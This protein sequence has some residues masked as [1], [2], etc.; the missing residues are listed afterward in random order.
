MKKP[1]NIVMLCLRILFFSVMIVITVYP[2]LFML[3][4]SFKTPVEFTHNFWLPSIKGFTFANYQRVW[5]DYKFSQYFTNSLIVSVVSTILIIGLSLPAGYAFVKLKFPFSDKIF[6]LILAVMFVPVFV[7]VIPLFV[8]MRSL[9]ATNTL[10]S[11]ISVYVFFGLPQAVFIFRNSFY[12]LPS[13]V[14]EACRVDG[15]NHFKVFWHVACPLSLPALSC[16]AILSFIN[17]WGEYIWAV[18]SNTKDAYTTIPAALSYFTTMSN[19]FWWYQMAALSISI[20]P[21][22]HRLHHFQ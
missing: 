12:S 17:C 1:K 22:D 13:G 7:Y 19:V 3:Q 14:C 10:Y 21:G 20:V 4:T 9:N 2:L 16:I 15:A 5:V 11:L 18:V 8:Q 6:S